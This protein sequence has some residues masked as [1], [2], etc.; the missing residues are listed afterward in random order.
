[1]PKLNLPEYAKCDKIGK[2]EIIRILESKV[3]VEIISTEPDCITLQS[4]EGKTFYIQGSSAVLDK[5][6]GPVLTTEGSPDLDRILSGDQEVSWSWHPSE[7][8]NTDQIRKSC[9]P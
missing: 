5:S 1:M 9:Y 7:D 3:E 6:K 2:N 4:N 8:L